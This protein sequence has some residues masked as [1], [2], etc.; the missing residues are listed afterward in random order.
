MKTLITAAAILLASTAVCAEWDMPFFGDGDNSSNGRFIGN[1][2]GDSSGNGTHK[3]NGSADGE[4]EFSFAMNF[5]GR[6]NAKM[7]SDSNGSYSG[8]GRAD[9]NTDGNTIS[10][11]N[12]YPSYNGVYVPYGYNPYNA[13]VVPAPAA[14]K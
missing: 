5:K 11:S 2:Y 9:I 4:G 12:T 1:G 13:P 14:A 10:N 8:N 7:D 6:G 3:G